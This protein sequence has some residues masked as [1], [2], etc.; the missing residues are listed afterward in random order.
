MKVTLDACA[1]GAWLPISCDHKRVLDIGAG[2]GLLSLMVAQKGAQQVDAVEIDQAAYQ[3]ATENIA[4]S[5]FTDLINLHH[6]DVTTM[7]WQ[8]L[9]D[10]IICNPPFFSEHLKGPDPLRNQ[11]RHNDGLSFLQLCEIF[12]NALSEHGRAYV[13]LPSTELA[14]FTQAAQTQQLTILHV[15]QFRSRVNKPHHRVF[16]TL[17]RTADRTEEDALL[18]IYDG[19]NYSSEFVALMHPYYLNL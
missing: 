19:E 9:Y 5:P 17:S 7:K 15:L 16:I 18:T 13:L 8:G 10:A 1:F 12:S 14:R 2:T 11:A 6:R 4:R 3:Q